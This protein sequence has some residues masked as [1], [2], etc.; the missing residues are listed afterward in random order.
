MRR[1]ILPLFAFFIISCAKEVDFNGMDN[2]SYSSEDLVLSVE[3]SKVNISKEE[4][5]KIAEDIVSQFP[6]RWADI[7]NNIVP[8]NSELQYN[9]LGFKSE[10]PCKTVMSPNF[11][12]WLIRIE[13]D[14]LIN[15]G[16][17][18]MHVFV[19][20]KTGEIEKKLLDGAVLYDWDES[21]YTFVE[22]NAQPESISTLSNTV[23]SVSSASKKWAVIVNGGGE[24]SKNYQRYWNDCQD[25]YIKLTQNLGYPKSHIY[26]LCSDGTN[27]AADRKI[28]PSTY[29][30]SPLDFD[31]DGTN[32]IQYSAKKNN[33]KDVLATIRN[34][35][36]Y[37]DELLLYFTGHGTNPY[38]EY[39]M[40]NS[41]VMDYV[42]LQTELNKFSQFTKIDVVMGQCGSGK[43]TIVH[44]DNITVSTA[45]S[46]DENSHGNTIYNG[47][48]YFLHYWAEALTSS[49]SG[50]FNPDPDG[51][52][53][54]SIREQFLY[55]Q[56]KIQ[57]LSLAET[58][59]YRSY[60]PLFGFG[61][62]LLN[63]EFY[64]YVSGSD[65]LSNNNNCNYTY[66]GIPS[67]AISSVQWIASGYT[68]LVSSN[69][70][71]ATVRGNLTI[72]SEYA[73]TNG[74]VTARFTYNG[75]TY[76]VIKN[77]D[78]IWKPGSYMGYQH[79]FGNNGLYHVTEYQGGYGYYWQ[80]D[81]PSWNVL[82]QGSS[83]VSVLEGS[84]SAS[85]NL[86]VGFF[87]PFGEMVIVTDRV[88]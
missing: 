67:S 49:S 69:T 87:T 12:S 81:N 48:E 86:T 33:L 85:V 78:S 57:S 76:D 38:G 79:I 58:P 40:W 73:S 3:E 75:E 31:G 28:G 22:N 19:N 6:D 4:A 45:C 64:P 13:S 88:N 47:Y 68:T 10:I 25:I 36:G 59:K 26:C 24:K 34:N 29:D 62:D 16:G 18:A 70:S 83:E 2:S 71:S 11:D 32:D 5:L 66:S 42:F 27:S 7:S 30:S 50:T 8:A 14:P 74:S 55:A 37:G 65:Y 1:I 82:S 80:S 21:R 44:G 41:E 60:K 61:H 56:G 72:S 20:V 35:M 52:G 15:G 46:A 53:Y 23:Q 17:P 54:R 77:I 63:N 84:A 43:F 39:V 51:N 9:I